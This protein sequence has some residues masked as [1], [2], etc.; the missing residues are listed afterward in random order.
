[1]AKKYFVFLLITSIHLPV[2]FTAGKGSRSS[3]SYNESHVLW[4]GIYIENEF[5]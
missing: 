2:P 3:F 1:M 5:K 4:T